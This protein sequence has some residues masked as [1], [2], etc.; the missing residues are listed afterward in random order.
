M[1]KQNTYLVAESSTCQAVVSASFLKALIAAKM[2]PLPEPG[3]CQETVVDLY[4]KLVRVAFSIEAL[5][6]K[7]ET[8]RRQAAGR[9]SDH[10]GCNPQRDL[11]T[12]LDKVYKSLPVLVTKA[13]KTH[14]DIQAAKTGI[15]GA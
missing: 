4:H 7:P 10:S 12:K 5:Q 1:V 11:I 3:Q 15:V 13:H 2:Y 9:F 6:T 14:L 8:T